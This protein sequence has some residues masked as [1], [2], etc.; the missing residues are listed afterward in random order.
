[1]RVAFRTRF[2]L[3]TMLPIVGA[4]VATDAMLEKLARDEVE[5]DA[6]AALDRVLGV[7]IR[8]PAVLDPPSPAALRAHVRALG[9]A[10][11]L[12]VSVIGADGRVLADSEV[13]DERVDALP[14]HD[15][16]PE[17]ADAMALGTGRATRYSAT[18]GAPL[19]YVARRVDAR[20]G[21]VV[22]RLATP[23]REL[24]G[25]LASRRR[26]VVA[27]TAGVVLV[28]S[29][30]IWAVAALL[31]RRV[32]RLAKAAQRLAAGDLQAGASD[33]AGDELSTLAGVLQR[34]AA[35]SR[36]AFTR[37]E[38]DERRLRVVL[39]TMD[40]GVL[41]VS[42]DG[43]VTMVNRSLLHLAGHAG[44][45]IGRPV[46]ALV[47]WPEVLSAIAQAHDGRASHL[48]LAVTHPR[49]A[50]LRV[51]AG[52]LPERGGALVVVADA[53]EEHRLSQVR[54]DFVAN[55]SHELRNPVGTIQAAAETLV[56]VLPDPDEDQRRLLDTIGR[57]SR[58]MGSLVRDLLDLARIEAGQFPLHP[59]VL[60]LRQVAEAARAGVD[61]RAREKGVRLAV[62]AE[63]G[64]P[65]CRGDDAALST[66]LGNLLDNAVKYTRPGDSV[67]V[68][69]RAAGSA[70]EIDVADTGPGIPEAHLPRLFE[71]FYR[72]DAGRSR[73]LGGTGL[74]L[75]IVKHLVA[76]MGGSVRVRSVVGSGTT[77]T[78][79]LPA[80]PAPQRTDS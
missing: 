43:R 31:T 21:P 77:F 8:D 72:V 29:L 15:D 37:L 26:V 74:G 7:A 25:R 28:T 61:A 3:A 17:F 24:D 14:G 79:S 80:A 42:C 66:I 5:A 13:A 57:Q 12:R 27:T 67:T 47:C 4:A 35:E 18:L 51:H 46:S 9:L 78:V 63:A 36:D 49:A 69:I 60:D 76:A 1:M 45:A 19:R 23:L 62:E 68:R 38:A 64:S 73:E 16:R 10:A 50:V 40:E 2:F 11:D 34:I 6:G 32:T 75:A 30:G 39:E 22:V 48:E 56:D 20:S 70:V 52:P 71:R 58:R 44:D 65:G 55:V 41:A 53:T 54:R 33:S 59:A